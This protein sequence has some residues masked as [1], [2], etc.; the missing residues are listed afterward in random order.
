MIELFTLHENSLFFEQIRLQSSYLYLVS[1]DPKLAPQVP[2]Q[3]RFIF[4][5]SLPAID[6]Y[7]KE[8]MG[9]TVYMQDLIEMGVDVARRVTEV[10]SADEEPAPSWYRSKPG[11]DCSTPALTVLATTLFTTI[12]S[13][14]KMAWRPDPVSTEPTAA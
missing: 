4:G 13:H 1:R 8:L 6:Q 12:G 7:K 2:K 10:D 14:R 3:K 9:S 11:T 5:V